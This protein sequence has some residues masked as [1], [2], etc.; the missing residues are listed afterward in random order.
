MIADRHP[1]LGRRGVLATKHG[2]TDLIAPVMFR[3]LGL[4]VETAEVDTDVLGTFTRDVPR[5][6]SPLEVA[7]AKA[8]LGMDA[9]GSSIGFASEGSFGPHWSVPMVTVDVELVVMVDDVLGIVVAETEVDLDVITFSTDLPTADTGSLDL[10]RAG[11]P[12]HGLI[13]MSKSGH[14]PIV[15]GLHCKEELDEA[16]RRCFAVDPSSGV[17][18]ESD[19]RAHHHPS[20]RRVIARAAERLAERLAHSC[21]SCHAPGWGLG[22][23]ESGA[24]C[25]ECGRPTRMV[26][27]EVE[28]CARCD[29]EVMRP[30][31]DAAGV[32]PRFCPRCNP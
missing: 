25:L 28:V 4:E 8:R 14:G 26:R 21:P 22:R 16:V 29:V 11:F 3:R 30:T 13:V 5:R 9:T 7:V 12:E 32:D 20:R 1:F 6:G 23:R 15:K 24:P 2:K 18:V 31:S 10:E 19:F 27:A 17:R